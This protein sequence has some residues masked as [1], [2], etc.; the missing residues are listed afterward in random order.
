MS[1]ELTLYKTDRPAWIVQVTPAWAGALRDMDPVERNTRWAGAGHDLKT[2]VLSH[3]DDELRAI[4][5]RA[6]SLVD[7]ADILSCAPP[8]LKRALWGMTDEIM[9]AELHR[10]AE[11]RKAAA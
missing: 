8:N 7:M 1:D 5:W 9:R 2:A 4:L 11:R 3:A 6:T 10:F